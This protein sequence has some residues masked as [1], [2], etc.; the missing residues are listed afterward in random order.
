MKYRIPHA[1]VVVLL[2]G[3]DEVPF[4]IHKDLLCIHSGYFRTE[5]AKDHVDKV[6]YIVKFP[7]TLVNI[8]GC[9]Q[10]FIYTGKVYDKDGGKEIPDYSLLM[11]L[12]KLA[13]QLCTAHLKVAVLNTMIERRRLTSRIPGTSLLIQAWKETEE[14][15]GLR[16]LLIDWAAEHCRFNSH[17]FYLLIFLSVLK[18]NILEW[19][20]T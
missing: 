15:S 2:V 8:F 12:W 7:E 16:K 6:E 1:R 11:G 5:F 13:T 19:R 14:G 20:V 3:P 4:T 10:N 18:L 17:V 9:F